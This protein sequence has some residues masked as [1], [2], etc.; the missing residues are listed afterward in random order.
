[1]GIGKINKVK[2]DL[3]SYPPYIFLAP[4]KFG[5]TSFWY[6]LVPYVWGDDTKGLLISFGNEEGYHSLDGIQVE[7]AKDWN[8]E[9]DEETGLRGFVQIVDDIV[10]NNDEYGLKGVCFDTLDTF[11][12]VATK[13]VLRQ[14]RKEKG[15]SCKTLN[16]AFSGYGRGKVR[17]FQIC[18][19]QIERLRD[20]GLA[21]FILCHVK[22]KEKTD[23]LS[24]EKYEQITNNLTDDIFSNFA[25]AAQIVMTGAYDREISNGKLMDEKRVV[26]LRGNSTVDAGGRFTN[27][28]EKIDLDVEQFMDAFNYAVKN[29]IRKGKTDDKTIERM[30]KEE[31]KERAEKAAI[32]KKREAKNAAIDEDRNL[33]LIEMMS[34][35]YAD[36][37][38]DTRAPIKAKTKELGVKNF[39]VLANHPTA[40][41]EDLA[42][43]FHFEEA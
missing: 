20:I 37:D 6:N 33:E 30:K 29:S 11:I 43:L 10:E 14:H 1:M 9:L 39:K 16:E 25:D 24:G 15:T 28:P 3:C 12:D 2:A 38:A 18:N 5:K 22:N 27:I 36:M 40:E 34:K 26:Y 35:A 13:E 7:V 31:E 21:V 32:A 17:L 42:A 23:L 8:S 41:L 19:A 4:K